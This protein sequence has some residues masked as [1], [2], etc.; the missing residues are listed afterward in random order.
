MQTGDTP[1]DLL[2]KFITHPKLARYLKNS[3]MLEYSAHVIPE[4][5]LQMVPDLYGDGILVAG[6]AAALCNVTGLNLEGVNFASHSGILAAETVVQA[7]QDN[8]YTKEKLG[9]YKKKLDESFVLQDLKQHKNAPRMLH[10]QRIYGDYPDALCTMM[11]SIYKI[12][13]EPRTNVPGIIKRSL[14]GKIGLKNLVTDTFSAWR[15][16]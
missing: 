6:D 10:N 15:S 14:L 2:N 3:T 11:E 1:Y 12:D 5:G 8:E 13:G 9:L 16:V 4:G 7:V